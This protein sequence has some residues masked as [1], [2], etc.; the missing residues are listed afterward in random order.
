MPAF[1]AVVAISIAGFTLS[2]IVAEPADTSPDVPLIVKVYIPETVGVPEIV[3]DEPLG[4]ADSPG[5]KLP[6]T[7]RVIPLSAVNF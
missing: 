5:G 3:R 6:I 7:L 1:R 4:Y 2:V